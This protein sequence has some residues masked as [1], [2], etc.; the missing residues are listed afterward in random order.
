MC[1][2][3]PKT[4]TT[5]QWFLNLNCWI[6]LVQQVSVLVY[7]NVFGCFGSVGS[8]PHD[9]LQC[10][11]KTEW[12][13]LRISRVATDTGVSLMVS[14]F[15]SCSRPEW[16][17][18]LAAVE[19]SLLHK[20]WSL[21]KPMS[22]KVLDDRGHLGT[23]VKLYVR[24][25]GKHGKTKNTACPLASFLHVLSSPNG[26]LL[27][28]YWR[29]EIFQSVSNY[30]ASSQIFFKL[31]STMPFSSWGHAGRISPYRVPRMV[32]HDGRSS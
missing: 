15:P 5:N 20:P 13:C 28:V 16:G 2:A 9:H 32:S 19:L 18:E 24:R 27:Q 11:L 17:F 14:F 21:P 8:I 22:L 10:A 29:F 4:S 31:R 7:E 1:L 3:S 30:E 23:W 25:P 12:Q 26:K 6:L